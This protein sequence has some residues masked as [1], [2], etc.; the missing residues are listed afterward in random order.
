MERWVGRTALITGASVGFGAAIAK[1]LVE[2]GMKVIG[3]ARNVEKIEALAATLKGQ[4]GTLIPVQCD[5]AKE[6]EILAMFERIKKEHG[7]VDVCVNNAGLSHNAPLL[8]GKTED[9][10]HMLEVNV[11]G[12]CICTRE[13]VKLMKE[14]GVDDGHIF[15]IS[16]LSGHRVLNSPPGH[17]YAA[18]KFAVRALQEG[19]RYELVSMKSHIRVTTISP[20][21]AETEFTY[22]AFPDNP[23]LAKSKHSQFENLQVGDI[24]DSVVY[25]LSAPARCQVHDILIRPTEQPY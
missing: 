19:L 15:L 13:S 21:L 3:C 8:S 10:R 24:A 1:R 2:H 25:A 6:D 17:M 5:L 23:E 12:L 14:R 4:K 18:T 7:C 22:R 20:G 9:W 16:S 11:L